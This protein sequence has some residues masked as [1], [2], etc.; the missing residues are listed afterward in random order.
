MMP[1]QRRDA[2]ALW[3]TRAD[4]TCKPAD[5]AASH[6]AQYLFATLVRARAGQCQPDAVCSCIEL[7]DSHLAADRVTGVDRQQKLE[8]HLAREVVEVAADLCRDRRGQETVHEQ[9]A[10]G[11]GDLVM[12]AGIARNARERAHVVEIE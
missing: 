10:I 7:R 8:V 6:D 1:E 12:C 11:V 3:T 2:T 5:Y 9:T 4:S